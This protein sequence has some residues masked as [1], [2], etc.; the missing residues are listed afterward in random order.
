MQQMR[1]VLHRFTERLPR[2]AKSQGKNARRL[3]NVSP[4]HNST[5]TSNPQQLFTMPKIPVSASRLATTSSRT[6]IPPSSYE[7]AFPYS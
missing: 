1:L 6:D 3:S 2:M 4:Y 5:N 7:L